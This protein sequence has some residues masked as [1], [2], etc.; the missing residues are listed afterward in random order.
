MN[1]LLTCPAV[2]RRLISQ[3]YARA[4]F[5][6]QATQHVPSISWPLELGRAAVALTGVAVWGL[7]I[8]LLA[9]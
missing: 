7:A 6:R 2:E 1:V 5:S 9:G 8:F 4:F 3:R